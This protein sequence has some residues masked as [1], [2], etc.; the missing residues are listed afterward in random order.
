MI[1]WSQTFD[2][3]TDFSVITS[4][5]T[6]L[7]NNINLK[8]GLL[9]WKHKL[10]WKLPFKLGKIAINLDTT[11]KEI[12]IISLLP[13]LFPGSYVSELIVMFPS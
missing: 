4:L 9:N 2:V 10:T 7:R 5:E 8:T 11:H 1:G 12:R 13:I 3:E 6:Y